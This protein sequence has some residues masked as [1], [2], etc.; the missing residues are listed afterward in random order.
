MLIQLIYLDNFGGAVVW[1]LLWAWLGPYIWKGWTGWL[2]GGRE[3]E[4]KRERRQKEKDGERVKGR[5]YEAEW[6]IS[7]HWK[8]FTVVLIKQ[9]ISFSVGQ[10]L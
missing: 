1:L 10:T 9:N 8:N 3:S 2:K 6:F 7:L 5:E 4:R